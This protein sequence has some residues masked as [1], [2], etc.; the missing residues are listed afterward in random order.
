MRREI[1]KKLLLTLVCFAS[2][3]CVMSQG[4]PMMHLREFNKHFINVDTLILENAPTVNPT[5]DGDYLFELPKA[6]KIV[7]AYNV[8]S[9]KAIVRYTTG[10]QFIP[11]RVYNVKDDERRLV[12]WYKDDHVYCGYVYDKRFK[13]GQYYEAFNEEE[14]EKIISRLPFMRHMPNFMK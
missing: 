6:C 9:T 8:D 5:E 12:L 10:F 11:H 7:I 4:F 2:V 3:S 13:A 14:R 1:F